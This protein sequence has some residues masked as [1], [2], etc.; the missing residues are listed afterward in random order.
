[1]I[2]QGTGLKVFWYISFDLLVFGVLIQLVFGV[3]IQLTTAI[4]VDY[5]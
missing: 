2:Y 3:L 5:S 4:T 1:M